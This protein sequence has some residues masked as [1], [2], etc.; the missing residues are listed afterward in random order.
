MSWEGWALSIAALGS[1]LGLLAF[2]PG[3]GLVLPVVLLTV[4]ALVAACV[5]KGSSP[6]GPGPSARREFLEKR[7]NR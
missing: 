1:T 6:G 4:A 3:S 5:L 2:F 7:E